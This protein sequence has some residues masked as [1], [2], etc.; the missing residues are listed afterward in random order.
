MDRMRSRA[1]AAGLLIC[2]PGAALGAPAVYRLAEPHVASKH[3][4][5]WTSP[6]VWVDRGKPVRITGSVSTT[7]APGVSAPI[8]L[9]FL[10][11]NSQ[12]VSLGRVHVRVI[13][14]SAPNADAAHPCTRLDFEIRQ[15]PHQELRIPAGRTDLL[16]L[17]LPVQQWPTFAMRNRPVNQDGC[18]GARLTLGYQA[19]GERSP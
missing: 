18:K 14:V 5:Q 4:A 16:G 1:V 19:L 17:R 9:S 6:A 8:A 2:L 11:P 7:L 12:P 3:G 10:N 15:M 13:R